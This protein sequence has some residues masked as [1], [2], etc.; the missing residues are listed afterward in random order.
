MKK[1]YLLAL[2]LLDVL[3]FTACKKKSV[4][5]DGAIAPGVGSGACVIPLALTGT[6][7]S[8]LSWQQDPSAASL[9]ST[10]KYGNHS[11]LA[12]STQFNGDYLGYRVV[13]VSQ[14]DTDTRLIPSPAGDG[15]QCAHGVTGQSNTGYVEIATLCA[16]EVY[17]IFLQACNQSPAACSAE[18]MVPAPYLQDRNRDAG[19]QGALD[20]IASSQAAVDATAAQAYKAIADYYKTYKDTPNPTPERAQFLEMAKNVVNMGLALYQVT[21]YTQYQK[22]LTTVQNNMQLASTTP[23]STV[24][25]GPGGCIPSSQILKPG[26]GTVT[27]TN[28]AIVPPDSP[29]M[30]DNTVTVETTET[31]TETQASEE[32]SGRTSAQKLELGLG[33]TF[34]TLGVIIGTIGVVAQNSLR[35]SSITNTAELSKAIAQ[36]TP[37]E[38]EVVRT[39]AEAE[40]RKKLEGILSTKPV[41]AADLKV[42]GTRLEVTGIVGELT[43]NGGSAYNGAIEPANKIEFFNAAGDVL[44]VT[45]QASIDTAVGYRKA[46]YEDARKIMQGGNEIGLM[47]DADGSLRLSAADPIL[48]NSA[49]RS[50]KLNRDFTEFSIDAEVTKVAAADMPAKLASAVDNAKGLDTA[51][52]QKYG[53]L[54]EAQKIK[55]ESVK[56]V[57]KIEVGKVKGFDV[58]TINTVVVVAMIVLVVVGAILTAVGGSGLAGDTSSSPEADLLTAL[59]PLTQTMS[60]NLVQN[61]GS[62]VPLQTAI[63]ASTAPTGN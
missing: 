19:V 15:T 25:T 42:A 2:C 11:V 53:D 60:T 62:Y 47:R 29:V 3:V 51:R 57:K 40:L 49:E 45:N 18:A 4:S 56:A 5:A 37:I 20:G 1:T 13:S 17:Q 26:K 6:P 50:L 33:I 16:G 28:T 24:S 27:V 22:T 48:T 54:V 61:M 46:V 55:I 9:V 8:E 35:K 31:K 21:I 10:V 32:S 14:P 12:L 39:A 36:I 34:L 38:A 52:L 7:A 58:G 30:V 23:A 59:S 41:V 43:I 63:T 44:R